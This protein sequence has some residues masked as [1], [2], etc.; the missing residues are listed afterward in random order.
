MA[1]R[2]TQPG[3]TP[4]TRRAG[5]GPGARAVPLL[6]LLAMAIGSLLPLRTPAPVPADA[7]P[8][9]F[10]A[11]RAA[12]DLQRIAR[13]PR[14][15][16]STAN[17]A[18]RGY[19]IE[20]LRALGYDPQPVAGV[21][22]AGEADTELGSATDVL[23]RLSGTDPTGTVILTAHYDSVPT[24]SGASDDGAMVAAILE[25]ARILR[26][27]PVPRNDI[28]IL[29]T[30]SEEM[31]HIGAQVFV[32]ADLVDP[33]DAVVVNLEA[34]GT[35]GPAVMFES[36]GQGL[37]PAIRDSGAMA[38]SAAAAVYALLPNS[39]DMDEYR[40][41]GMRGLNFAITDGGD[42][43]HTSRDTIEA[44]SPRSLQDMGTAALGAVRRLASSDLD[45]PAREQVY[46]EV[47]GVLL[48]YPAAAE[49]PLLAL[50]I[51]VLLAAFGLSARRG[52]S[53]RG[54]LRAVLTFPLVPIAAVLVSQLTWNGIVAGWPDAWLTRG[55]LNHLAVHVVAGAAATT[56]PALLWH[57][58]VRRRAGQVEASLALLVWLTGIG[59]LLT[60]VAPA[61]AFLFTLPALVG[62][63]ATVALLVVRRAPD[64]QPAAAA[65]AVAVPAVAVLL[66]V[67]GI[68]PPVLGVAQLGIAWLALSFPLAAA[69]GALDVLPPGRRTVAAL[70][71]VPLAAVGASLTTAWRSGPAPGSPR[72]VSVG[73]LLE[74][75]GRTAHW[76]SDG[77]AAQPVVGDLLTAPPR[78]FDDVAPLLGAGSR[79]N[80]PAPAV[81][82]GPRIDQPP[83]TT[84]GGARRAPLRIR[85]PAA[86]DRLFVYL[87]VAPGDLLGVTVAG[88][89]LPVSGID[90]DAPGGWSWWCLYTAP[91]VEGIDV[92]VTLRASSTAVARVVS[93]SAGLPE[94]A[95]AP[96]L[97]AGLYW[98]AW[99]SVTDQTVVARDVAL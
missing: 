16:G 82:D 7:P 18:V 6:L 32:Q 89:D 48:S 91:P 50:G 58:F 92:V 20:R 35:S 84:S 15:A 65:C 11:E 96:A 24:G 53:L 25:I 69:A 9:Q 73:Y 49:L 54:V 2:T 59:L 28:A 93:I 56:A 46:F 23:A 19:L 81:A 12:A 40:R 97:P 60:L 34:R 17:A 61:A 22:R 74:A 51:L 63:A 75:D 3:P 90:P 38:T 14:P 76:I 26:A 77:T 52:S 86:G 33:A 87:D 79:S 98:A 4:T 68:L 78:R 21:A 36:V 39:T 71:A 42:R 70:L 72:P 88:V 45:A 64:V 37:V 29:L 30:D 66:P 57:R 1:V 27:D 5:R 95:G 99:P 94:A 44:A 41:A 13:E 67:C 31:G 85:P 43:Y 55:F 10:S 83:A 47:L 8:G 80:G 62:A